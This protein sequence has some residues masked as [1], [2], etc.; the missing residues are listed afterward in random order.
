MMWQVQHLRQHQQHED[1][2]TIL[3]GW[4]KYC[5]VVPQ[6]LDPEGLQFHVNMQLAGPFAASCLLSNAHT[7][8]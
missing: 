6:Q 5:L 3:A 4:H 2:L 1:T 7:T 8:S